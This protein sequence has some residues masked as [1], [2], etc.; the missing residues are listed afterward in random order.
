MGWP[1]GTNAQRTVI[2]STP[3][4]VVILSTLEEGRQIAV[5][6]I[7]R[8]KRLAIFMRILTLRIKNFVC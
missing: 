4:L 8:C 1:G 6:V 3:D 5:L 7:L 2:D